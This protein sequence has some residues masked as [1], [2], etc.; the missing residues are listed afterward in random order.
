MDLLDT[1]KMRK[2]ASQNLV[3]INRICGLPLL[4]SS[5][6]LCL[7]LFLIACHLYLHTHT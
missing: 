6:E 5:L 2:V 7:E 3:K 4:Y 1:A